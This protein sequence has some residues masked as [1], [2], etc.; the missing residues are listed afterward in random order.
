MA[1]NEIALISLQQAATSA[2]KQCIELNISLDT[3]PYFNA[4]TT[5]PLSESL[6]RY[7]KTLYKYGEYDPV[8]YNH[9]SFILATVDGNKKVG[10]NYLDEGRFFASM[11]LSPYKDIQASVSTTSISG[12]NKYGF[13]I[14]TGTNNTEGYVRFVFDETYNEDHFPEEGFVTIDGVGYKEREVILPLQREY[15]VVSTRDYYPLKLVKVEQYKQFKVTNET[16]GDFI[17]ED[18]IATTDSGLE[19]GLYATTGKVSCIVDTMI[20]DIILNTDATVL[21][22]SPLDSSSYKVLKKYK[23][24]VSEVEE[25]SGR[26]QTIQLKNRISEMQDEYMKS[27]KPTE[28]FTLKRLLDSCLGVGEYD[29][30]DN[31]NGLESHINNTVVKQVSVESKT[32]YDFLLELCQIGMFNISFDTRFKIWRVF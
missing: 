7:N 5:T 25:E 32:K 29:I 3:S 12:N 14:D 30:I 23:F 26:M 24:T 10:G 31:G 8:R 2:V 27:I 21:L 6:S 15:R 20:K 18:Q 19:F 17:I 4:T 1:D 11:A 16:A 9:N 28:E 13:L 22:Y